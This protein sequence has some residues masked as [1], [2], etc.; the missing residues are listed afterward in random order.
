MNPL[1]VGG[2]F[3][4][5]K[6]LIQRLFPNPEERAKHEMELLKMQQ[7]GELTELSTRMSAIVTEANSNDPWTSRARP[8]FMY[9]FYF[10]ILNLV[11]VAPFV[12]IF[13]P[14]EMETFFKN[15]DMGFQ[16]IPEELWWTFSA[17]YLGYA[18]LRTRE[19]EKGV[20]K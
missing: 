11:V 1:V 2:I 10:V 3:E 15:V 9:L 14:A 8:S 7:S 6:E 20:A 12:G 17:G 18:G 13:F 19:K 16:A 4:V 5:G